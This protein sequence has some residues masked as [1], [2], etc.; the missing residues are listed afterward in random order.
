MATAADRD[1]G[2]DMAKRR[3]DGGEWT[4]E[5]VGSVLQ[6]LMGR[7]DEQDRMNNEK[8]KELKSTLGNVSNTIGE[9]KDFFKRVESLENKFSLKVDEDAKFRDE[10]KTKMNEID[11]ML[12][13]MIAR[14][15]SEAGASSESGSVLPIPSTGSTYSS[16]RAPA[17][18]LANPKVVQILGFGEFVQK[19]KIIQSAKDSLGATPGF[20]EL[21]F[22]AK[23]VDNH[24]RVI[25]EHDA[26]AKRFLQARKKMEDA[27]YKNDYKQSSGKTVQLVV[28]PDRPLALRK[29]K[30]TVSKILKL[31]SSRIEGSGKNVKIESNGHMVFVQSDNKGLDILAIVKQGKAGADPETILMDDALKAVGFS[32]E[33]LTASLAAA[34]KTAG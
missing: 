12:R 15:S 28:K 22:S 19:D 14:G 24:V 32:K 13:S 11:A 3:A 16:A 17:G 6:R 25:F 30:Q 1:Q 34:V 10:T 18:S 33:E 2:G 7:M 20:A 31:V 21:Q 5:K 4:M 23:W 8:D 9:V 26:E 29:Q 27:G